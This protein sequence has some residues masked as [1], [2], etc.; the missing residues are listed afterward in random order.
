MAS[1]G[2]VLKRIVTPTAVVAI[3]ATGSAIAVNMATSAEARWWWWLIV[4]AVTAIGFGGS[5]WQFLRQADPTPPPTL[6][7]SGERSVAA[8]GTVRSISTGN[9]GVPSPTPPSGPTSAPP[10]APVPGSATASGDRSI[11]FE[12]NAS[13]DFS[14]GDR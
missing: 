8:R 1:T 14:T 5:L 11:A 2:A 4:A 10:A 7:A 12:G 13:G 3:A 9:V 6:T